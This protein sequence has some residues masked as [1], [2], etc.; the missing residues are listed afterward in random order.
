MRVKRLQFLLCFLVQ[1][2]I[3]LHA[4]ED[5]PV[6]VIKNEPAPA[7]MTASTS[8]G[9]PSSVTLPDKRVLSASLDG[10]ALNVRLGESALTLIDPHASRECPPALAAFADGSAL[11]VWRGHGKDDLRD[12][13]YAR[14]DEGVWQSSALLAYDHWRSP[15]DPV[16]EGPALDARGPHVAVAWFTTDGGPRINVSTSANAGIQWLMPVRVDDVTPIGRVS[17]V[18]LDDGAQLVSWVE[19]VGD[20][21]LI[22]L[23]RVSARN[24]L[25]VPVQLARLSID[26]GHPRLTRVK[27]GDATPAQLLLTYTEGKTPI[28]RLITLPT[29]ASLAETEA[30][31][32][33]PRPEELRGYALRGKITAVDAKAGTITLT[34]GDVP[35]VMKTTTTV[36]KAAPDL[37]AAAKPDQHV[38]ARTERIGPDWWLFSI[39]TLATP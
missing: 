22:L 25:S 3:C 8:A 12:L 19:H 11:L 15:S 24:T 29:A 5:S 7:S 2:V 35:G 31:D 20:T 21:Y 18:L 13:L 28:A 32:C 34:H 1:S 6:F 33:D 38:F 4:A 10:A 30:C 9:Q 27:D 16:N 36:F 17:I 37:L 39:R 14:F 23:R 26:P